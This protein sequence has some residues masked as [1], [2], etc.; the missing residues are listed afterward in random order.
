[1]EKQKPDE[2]PEPKPYRIRLPGFVGDQE[3]GLGDVIKK[4]IS[5]LGIKACGGCEARRAKL[6]R[7]VVFT[8][9]APR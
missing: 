4:G 8:R 7:R 5:Y 1:M 6:N 9:T 2:E 3:I